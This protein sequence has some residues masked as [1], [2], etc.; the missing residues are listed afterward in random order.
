MKLQHASAY[1]SFP[2]STVKRGDR[3]AQL[4]LERIFTPPIE[5]VEVILLH[6]ILNLGDYSSQLKWVVD[7]CMKS[8]LFPRLLSDLEAKLHSCKIKIWEWPGKEAIYVIIT[9][10]S[11]ADFIFMHKRL[12]MVRDL[13][14]TWFPSSF[15]SCH[16]QR[17]VLEDLAQQATNS[18]T[19]NSTL[20]AFYYLLIPLDTCIQLF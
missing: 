18:A 8:S 19:T 9:K 3:I 17:G 15:R 10:I 7:Q 2:S 1:D 20:L 16:P 12:G 4:V 14:C 6:G 13:C 5:E 11:Q